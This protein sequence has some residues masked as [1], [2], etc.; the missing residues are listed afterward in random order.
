[1]DIERI[2]GAAYAKALW[3]ERVWSIAGTLRKPGHQEHQ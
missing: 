3:L 1:M 2:P